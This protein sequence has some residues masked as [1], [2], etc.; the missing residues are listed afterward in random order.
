MKLK[1]I[2]LALCFGLLPWYIHTSAQEI[3]DDLNSKIP[4]NPTLKIGKLDNGITYYIR[5]N[6]KP[7][8]RV[9]LRL[10]LNAGSVLENED[11]LGLAHFTEHM[12][13]N[14]TKNFEKNELVNYLQSVGVKFGAHLNAYTSFDETVYKLLLP[15]DDKEILEKGMQ[16]LEDWAHNISFEPEEIDKERGV[17]VEEWRIGQGP[18]RRM[19]DKYLP[20]IYEDS[21]YAERLP[22]GTKENLENFEYE[23]LRDFYKTWYRPDLMAVVAVGDI[24]VADM[25]AMIKEKFGSVPPAENPKE[26]PVFDVPD[27]EETK[28]SV[29]TDPEATFSRVTIYYKDEPEAHTTLN[30]YRT[31]VMERLF[32]GMFNRRLQELTQAAEPPFMYAG[33]FYGGTWARTKNAFQVMAVVPE[34]G[35]EKGLKTVLEENEKI[36]RFGFTQGELDRYKNQLLS[37][38]EKA[39]NERDKSESGNY[40]D[41]YVRNFLEKE[42]IPG[43]AFEYKFVEKYL[44]G[45]NL[46]EVNALT[47][48]HI[49]N[50]NRVV[51]VTAQEKE[52]VKVPTEAEVIEVMKK[53]ED[54]EVVAYEDTELASTLMEQ[55]PQPGK[56]VSSATI[57]SI[58]VTTLKLS[59][60]VK[61]VLKPTDFKADEILMTASS[62]G[63]SSIY[64]DQDY[65]SAANADGIVQ[66]SGVK[67]FSL[68]DLQKFLSDKNA[69]ASPYISTLK[70]GLSGSATPK[71]LETMLQ[72]TYLY[73]TNPRKD[74]TAFQ[75]FISKNKSIYKNLLSNPQYYYFDQLSKILA[76][77]N[78]RGGG[79]PTEDDWSKVNF[80]KA[81]EVY[82]DR[83]A[84][85]SDFTFFFVGNFEVATIQ[86]LLEQYLG[87]LP[88]ISREE[89][90]RDL[91]IRPPDGK[92]TKEVMKGNDQKSFVTLSFN[93][94]FNYSQQN[95]YFLNSL[96]QALNIKL[97]E[98]IREEKSGVYGISASANP[99]KYPYEHYSITV[100]FPCAP[101]N[102]DELV[103][104][105]LAEISELKA[106][107]PTEA[108]INKVKETQ[109]R[110]M[111]TNLKSNNYWLSALENYYF[112][113]N[114]PAQIANYQKAIDSL[115]K[116]KL[117]E[118]AQQY[119]DLDNY[120]QVV[121]YPEE[122]PANSGK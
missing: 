11:Q 32:T 79:Y 106:N 90:W 104:G 26:R 50:N 31:S 110:E 59:N 117:K 39:Y 115:D 103:K 61:V 119:F 111:E 120:V 29:V 22:I 64:S 58:G 112:Y 9:E 15:S 13:F 41:E 14:G 121:L 49:N 45:I 85:A 36:K 51:V 67:D 114:D 81:F 37:V 118:V 82:N 66:Q 56:V 68:T 94:D 8:N 88:S 100:Q 16:I 28:V 73:F 102:V 72:L 92:V 65:L 34:N 60:G 54:S 97:I 3:S 86:P 109:R 96:I 4:D 35:V 71:D 7:E 57:D 98:K 77:N 53:V 93:G 47:K 40:A 78:P 91:G 63:G 70:E 84:D 75:S 95:A 6:T 23:T 38:Y 122:K 30:D 55:L 113:D 5:K 62:P 107:G 12:A 1:L 17:V 108:D 87:S 25:E 52:G 18:D 105:V 116:E 21:K 48:S 43:I 46:E 10:A 101:E 74:Q 83:F 20:V 80:D 76:Q 44:P 33:S 27:H 2:K 99:S 89:S 42:E 69:N 19:L 24:E